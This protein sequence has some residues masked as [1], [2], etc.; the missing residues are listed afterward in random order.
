M[1]FD[2]RNLPCQLEYR[3]MSMVIVARTK[4]EVDLEIAAMDKVANKINSSKAT[5]KAFLIKHGFITKKGNLTRR[6]R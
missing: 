2:L 1:E 5:A 3:H 6:Y 4:R